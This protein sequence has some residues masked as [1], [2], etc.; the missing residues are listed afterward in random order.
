MSPDLLAILPEVLL[1]VTGILIM[2]IEP[3]L[4]PG[5][6]RKPLGALAV[7]GSIAA[8][9]ASFYQL[10]VVNTLGSPITAF[11][12][13]IQVDSF[14][15]FFHLLIASIV[16]VTLLGS[17]NYFEKPGSQNNSASRV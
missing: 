12:A 13:T 1:T 7:I 11:Y 17:L 6:S 2:L 3:V 5:G 16:A 4:A 9:A 15:V 8:G 10:H 14:S